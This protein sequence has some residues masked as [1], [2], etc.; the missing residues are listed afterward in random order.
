MDNLHVLHL[1]SESQKDL[2]LKPVHNLMK[3]L[4]FHGVKS[5]ECCV[6]TK[7]DFKGALD[8]FDK[9]IVHFHDERLLDAYLWPVKMGG[10]KSVFTAHYADAHVTKIQKFL[11]NRLVANSE[12]VNGEV[13]AG[14]AAVVLDGMDLE[15]FDAELRKVKSTELRQQQG[16]TEDVFIIGAIGPLIKESDFESTIKALRNVVAKEMNAQ[17]VIAGEGEEYKPLL[18]AAEKL[19]VLDR[20]KIIQSSDYLSLFCLFDA[21]VV[22][23]FKECYLGTILGAMAAGIPVIATKIGANPEMIVQG[24]TGYLVPCGFP[25]RIDNVI[26]RWKAN[27]QLTKDIGQAGRQYVE[28]QFSLP[29]MGQKYREIYRF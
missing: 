14:K 28:E 18:K 29:V 23:S 1:Y 9:G 2:L 16:I 13:F 11:L 19:G 4:D 26:M 8:A 22:S 20:V 6:A 3:A 5:S 27:P 25:E 24:K 21:Y 17:L 15:D 10:Y 12:F 7:A